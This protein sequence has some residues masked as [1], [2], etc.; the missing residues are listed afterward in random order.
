MQQPTNQPTRGT[1][2]PESPTRPVAVPGSEGRQSSRRPQTT[3]RARPASR[4]TPPDLMSQRAAARLGGDARRK[5]LRMA[6]FLAVGLL[7]ATA[8]A[9]YALIWQPVSKTVEQVQETISNVFV[10]PVTVRPAPEGGPNQTPVPVV[11]P[12][13]DKHEPINILLLGLDYRPQE[14][15]SRADTMIIVHIDPIAKSASMVSI[16]RDMWVKVPGH[17]EERINASYQDGEDDTT[18]PGGG[19]GLAMATVE[20]NFGVKIHYFA[21]VDFAGFERIVDTMG[22]ITVDVPKPLVDNEYPMS[23]YAGK[24]NYGT[25]RIY[26]PA[27]LQ[28]MDGRTALQYARSRHADSDLGRNSR[29]QQVLMAIRHQGLSLDM[30]SHMNDVLSQLQ[31]A[32]KTDLTLWQVGSLAQLARDIKSDSIST[33]LID[34]SMLTETV[35][36]SGADV[37]V[38]DWTVIRPKIQQLFANPQVVKEAARLSVQN[39]TTT[40]GIARKLSDALAKDGYTISDLSSAPDQGK[41]PTTSIVDFTGGQ[42]PNTIDALLKDLNLPRSAV[43]QRDATDAILANSDGKPVDIL[44]IAGDDQIAKP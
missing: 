31:G 18:T 11:Y 17:G 10:T 4:Q 41:H 38:P 35:M 15:D 43:S 33:L 1:N 3:Y 24:A 21:Q 26:I 37:L 27:G 40:G 14:Q 30:I 22:G 39:G 23:S 5:R 8:I 6:I 34:N 2:T 29:Q 20:Y 44:V 9:A 42:K 12:N 32:V 13:W 36:P 28:R 7:G 19:P 16:P 25:T